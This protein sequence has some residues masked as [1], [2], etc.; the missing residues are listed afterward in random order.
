MDKRTKLVIIAI[1]VVIL[2]VVLY[3]ASLSPNE[4]SR[5]LWHLWY[6]IFGR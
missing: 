2:V 3:A 6:A 4:R 5:F 1:V